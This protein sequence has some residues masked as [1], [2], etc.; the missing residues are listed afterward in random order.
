MKISQ[1]FSSKKKIIKLNIVI[2]VIIAISLIVPVIFPGIANACTAMY[3]GKNVSENGHTVLCRSVDSHPQNETSCYQEFPRVENQPGRTYDYDEINFHYPL[4]DTTYRY[5]AVAFDSKTEVHCTNECINEYGLTVT[6]TVTCY[7]SPEIKKIDPFCKDGGL[8]ELVCSDLVCMCCKTARE[9]VEFVGKILD[10][11][12]SE[13]GNSIMLADQNEAWYMEW[14]SGHQWAA[15]KMPED[16]VSTYGNQFMIDTEYDINDSS[17]FLYSQN[18]FSMPQNAGLAVIKNGKMS[19]RETYCGKDRLWDYANLR[20]YIGHQIFSPS[21]VSAYNVKDLYPLFYSPDEKVSL[22]QIFEFF[23]N[24]FEGTP[25]SPDATGKT[26]VRVVASESSASVHAVEIDSEAPAEVCGTAWATLSAAE[27]G[28]FLPYSGYLSV[29]FIY[30]S[31]SSNYQSENDPYIKDLDK[32]NTLRWYV[33]E[34]ASVCYNKLSDLAEMDRKL[35]GVGVR[36]FWKEK[37][38]NLIKE[39]TD[40][41]KTMVDYY[42]QSPDKAKEYIETWS[43]NLQKES[44]AECRSMYDELT[45]Y[46]SLH[47]DTMKHSYSYDKLTI[48]DS[49]TEVAPFVPKMVFY[50]KYLEKYKSEE[51]SFIFKINKIGFYVGAVVVVIA[52]IS[53]LVIF[54]AKKKKNQ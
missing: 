48:S 4:P 11:K 50:G 46:C 54:I 2:C 44:L 14:Y 25:Y 19:L 43:K 39:Y 12:G 49:P 51:N 42:K 8:S 32:D 47:N 15:I 30:Y 38:A 36:N 5:T 23:R 52:I 22:N 28:I 3:V 13:T 18:L 29:P 21:T 6:A 34:S 37:E 27:H 45:W 9:G 53:A 41:Y 1:F 33:E 17:S 16:K 20:T 10:E 7:N 35:Y 40:V 26:D 24:R 31:D